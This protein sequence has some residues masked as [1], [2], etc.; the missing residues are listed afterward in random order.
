[1]AERD[2]RQQHRRHR[3]GQRSAQDRQHRSEPAGQDDRASGGRL[4]A[5]GRNYTTEN[6][7]GGDAT[8]KRRH[9]C[10]RQRVWPA[11]RQADDG[12]PLGAQRVDHVRHVR[13]PL[14]NRVVR[15]RVGQS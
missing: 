6:R 13:G 11:A 3:H 1:M 9:R 10:A 8:G 4:G 5:H 2:D 15:V 7:H 12:Q 14:G